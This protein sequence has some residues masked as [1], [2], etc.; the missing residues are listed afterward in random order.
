M[1]ARGFVEGDLV[2]HRHKEPGDVVA[3]RVVGF[4][5]D[6]RWVR[7]KTNDG[8]VRSWVDEHLLNVTRL[9]YTIEGF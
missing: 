2:L 6:R 4:G 1:T 8:R 9:G 7:V 5:P 3:G